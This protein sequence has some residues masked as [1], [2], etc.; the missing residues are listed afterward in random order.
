MQ[1]R[2]P[3]GGDKKKKKGKKI[4]LSWLNLSKPILLQQSK[5]LPSLVMPALF[6]GSVFWQTQRETRNMVLF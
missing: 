6:A 4:R 2:L 3:L 1:P 5:G